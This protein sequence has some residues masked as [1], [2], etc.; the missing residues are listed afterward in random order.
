M[1][2]QVIVKAIWLA[3][4]LTW[5]KPQYW[6]EASS[7]DVVLDASDCIVPKMC[8]DCLLVGCYWN[9]TMYI[10]PTSGII[11]EAL[12]H[13]SIHHFQEPGLDGFRQAALSYARDMSYL[14]T[15]EI[16]AQLPNVLG[17]IPEDLRAW[18]PWLRA[19]E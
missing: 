2:G 14:P 18:Y 4:V 1:I 9:G 16:H 12:L 11:K 6:V 10:N 19:Q 13:E 3:M 15:Y 7:L 17:Y 8:N 5:Y